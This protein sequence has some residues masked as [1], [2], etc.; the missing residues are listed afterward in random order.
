MTKSLLIRYLI[1]ILKFFLLIPGAAM[2]ESS[3]YVAFGVG[4]VDLNPE[5]LK[6]LR[7]A[8][9]AGSV[10]QDLLDQ[11]L[12]SSTEALEDQ[13]FAVTGY[14]GRAFTVRD[15]PVALELEALW[16]QGENLTA[17][18]DVENETLSIFVNVRIP[19][20]GFRELV[21]AIPLCSSCEVFYRGG[22]GAAYVQQSLFSSIASF[23]F[24][25]WQDAYHAGG[26]I[27]IPVTKRLSV[28]GH[29]RR[30]FVTDLE[31]RGAI[32]DEP[33]AASE[34]FPTVQFLGTV[35]FAI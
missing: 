17:E 7:A 27:T 18:A 23:D 12:N 3:T 20:F 30:L 9:G 26:G 13:N 21:K 16:S 31:F 25:E 19:A 34:R 8:G 6:G 14:V 10:S 22:F 33:F 35:R 24:E 32:N 2:A 28:E 5:V 1:V 4:V 11:A 15:F 29:I